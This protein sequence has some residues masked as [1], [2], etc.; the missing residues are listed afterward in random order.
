MNIEEAKEV[1]RKASYYVNN[2]WSVED[3]RIQLKQS[4]DEVYNELEL[5]DDEC[6]DILDSVL[7]DG[8]IME[9]INEDIYS[10]LV[11]YLES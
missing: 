11:I 5:D 6:Y 2:L 7:N 9:R 1:L 4:D 3:V 8:T 10:E